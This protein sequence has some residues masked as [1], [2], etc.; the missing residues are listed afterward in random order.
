MLKLAVA[1]LLASS[2]ILAADQPSRA[3]AK[4]KPVELPAGAV[5]TSP[6]MFR[7]TDSDGKKWIY[8]KTPFGLVRKEDKAEAKPSI[9]KPAADPTTFVEE[10]DLI[11][12]ERPGPFGKYRWQRK[13]SELT[14]SEREIVERARQRETSTA[15]KQD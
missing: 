1:V 12:F 6:G 8:H 2:P 9:A 7:Y 11:K 15:A 4:P 13:R 5:E 14:D 3:K 10:G